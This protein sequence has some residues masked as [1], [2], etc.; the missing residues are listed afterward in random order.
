MK[1]YSITLVVIILQKKI[2]LTALIQVAI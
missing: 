2:D 1:V